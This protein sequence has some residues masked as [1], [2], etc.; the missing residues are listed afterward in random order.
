MASRGMP[1]AIRG[2]AVTA[3]VL[4][5][6]RGAS[7]EDSPD[8]TGGADAGPSMGTGAG[9]TLSV[10]I[11]C[12]PGSIRVCETDAGCTGVAR[13]NETGDGR[14]D[15]ECI[16]GAGG[17][18]GDG[19]PTDA[20]TPGAPC[21]AGLCRYTT[22]GVEASYFCNDGSWSDGMVACREIDSFDSCPFGPFACVTPETDLAH[23]ESICCG[24][25]ASECS[26]CPEVAPEPGTPCAPT[27]ECSQGDLPVL[28]NC[29][30]SC[31]CYG[32]TTWAQCDGSVWRVTSNCSSK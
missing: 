19:C 9:P 28:M 20:P 30:Y 24:E 12:K 22:C 11:S 7:E 15:C 8:A 10:P 18:S 17:A 4:T 31:C 2:V 26:A 14:L 21:E 1:R 3:L 13:C 5:S 29:F 23:R 16:G 6:C 25:Y 32:D 27:D